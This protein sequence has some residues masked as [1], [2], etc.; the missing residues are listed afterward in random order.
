[1]SDSLRAVWQL[2]A[3]WR[4][5]YAAAVACLVVA[6]CLLYLVPLVTQIVLD[7]ALAPP[8]GEPSAVVRAGLALLGGPDFLRRNLWLAA[9]CIAGL[10]AVSGAFTYLRGYLAA[11]ASEGIARE[12]R[13]RLCDHLHHLPCAFYDHRETGDLIQRCTSD[14]ETLRLFLSGQ[15]TEIGRALIMLVIP[16]PLMLSIDGRM[17]MASLILVVPI[18]LFSALYFMRFRAAFRATDEAEGRMTA[19]IQEN[20][21]GIRVVKAFCRQSFEMERFE[22]RNAEHRDLDLNLYRQ[23]ARFWS[24]SDLLCLTQNAIVLGAGIYFIAQGTLAVGA[25]FFFLSAVNLFIWPVRMMGR[26]LSELGK[27]IVAIDRIHEILDSPE[28]SRPTAPAT[29]PL[30]GG[31]TFEDVVFSHAEE[32]PVLRGVSFHVDPGTTLAILGPSGSGKSTLVNLLL[33]FYDPDGGCIRLDGVDIATMPRQYV[34]SRISVVMQEP[35]LY[36]RTL[37][38]NIAIARPGLPMEAVIDAASTAALHDSI[39]HFERGYETVVGE[40]G[41][42]LSGGQR[43]RVAI[44]RAL[45]QEPAILI[46]DDALSAV[47]TETEAAILEAL[48]KRGGKHTTVIIAHRLSTLMHADEILVLEAGSVAQ[49]GRHEDLREA[50]SFYRRLWEIQES[51]PETSAR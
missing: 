19:R 36:S 29:P 4:R 12:V 21:T 17:T 30:R 24:M 18:V 31:I 9:V 51:E 16:I 5:R 26:L 41:V 1:M 6:S 22:E 48:R 33:R 27:A 11:S 7:G 38:E 44:A 37:G 3:G 20:L 14:V 39:K 46:L 42:T 43:Q 47:D 40:R 8:D 2:M 23:L 15:V 35:F 32:S 25:F 50:P 13:D 49:Q 45:V 34:R 10:T 28:E